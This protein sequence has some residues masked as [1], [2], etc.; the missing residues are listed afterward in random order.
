[1][2]TRH[3]VTQNPKECLIEI[4]DEKGLL[5]TFLYRFTQVTE[6]WC[7]LAF[8]I[9]PNFGPKPNIVLK[10]FTDTVFVGIDNFLKV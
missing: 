7:Q 3:T 1:M 9:Q 4:T 10:S 8:C 6:T 2:K 5:L